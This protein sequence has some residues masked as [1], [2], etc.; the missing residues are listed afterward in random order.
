MTLSRTFV[1]AALCW[2]VLAACSAKNEAAPASTTTAARTTVPETLAAE[3]SVPATI[4]V[5]TT[6]PEIPTPTSAPTATPPATTLS[7]DS[8]DLTDQEVTEI[9]QAL[10]ELDV[11]IGEVD[12]QL[13]GI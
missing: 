9:E 13:G 10:D 6:L 1:I 7:I 3:T 12:T 4:A 2:G 11:L 8:G 5:E